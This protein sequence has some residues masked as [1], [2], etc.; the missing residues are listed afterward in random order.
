MSESSNANHHYMDLAHHFPVLLKQLHAGLETLDTFSS[1]LK[2]L[3]AVHAEAE[4]GVKKIIDRNRE[5]QSFDASP[6]V[7][8]AI[9]SVQ[10]VVE[11]TCKIRLQEYRQVN[12]LVV[13]PIVDYI[14]SADK[15]VKKI[16]RIYNEATQ[17]IKKRREDVRKNLGNCLKGWQQLHQ[18]KANFKRK[19]KVHKMFQDHEKL[20]CEV[21]KDYRDFYNMELK[22]WCETLEDLEKNR[23]GIMRDS[24][25]AFKTA[26]FSSLQVSEVLRNDFKGDSQIESVEKSFQHMMMK[27]VKIYGEA[28]PPQEIPTGLPCHSFDLASGSNAWENK[29]VL[30]EREKSPRSARTDNTSPKS[31]IESVDE[32]RDYIKSIAD[33]NNTEEEHIGLAQ[34]DYASDNE[35]DLSFRIGDKIIILEQDKSGWWTGEL[36][37]KIGFFPGNY[38]TI[39]PR[40]QLLVSNKSPTAVEG[41]T[42]KVFRAKL[43][44]QGTASIGGSPAPSRS[45]TRK[46]HHIRNRRT[47][48]R[49]SRSTSKVDNISLIKDF[50]GRGET[51]VTLQNVSNLPL[52]KHSSSRDYGISVKMSLRSS[53]DGHEG[54]SIVHWQQKYK[55]Q[56]PIWNSPRILMP[57]SQS[58][59]IKSQHLYAVLLQE[60]KEEIGSASIPLKS[61]KF[62]VPTTVPV[63]LPKEPGNTKCTLSLTVSKFYPRPKYV[64]FIRHGESEWNL[65]QEKKQVVNMM[66]KV[67]HGLS[68]AGR[69]QAESLADKIRVAIENG[70]TPRSQN[71]FLERFIEADS[72][73][74]S[75]LTRALQTAVIAL[76]H[77]PRLHDGKTVLKVLASARERRNFGGR[78]TQGKRKGNDILV[79]LQHKLERLYKLYGGVPEDVEAIEVDYNDASDEWWDKKKESDED[80]ATRLNHLI[81]HLIFSEEENIIL[82][83]H[84]FLIRG[85]FQQFLGETFRKNNQ[86]VAK[87]FM[88]YKLCNCAVVGVRFSLGPDIVPQIDDVRLLLGSDIESH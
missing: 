5:K 82:V 63:Y 59:D 70:D 51:V 41:K 17:R 36:N 50:V 44:K 34:W 86:Q 56:N 27:W 14:K 49:N 22:Q 21:N 39:M 43:N 64:F 47:N 6:D 37:G 18:E 30:K 29:S 65:A 10:I 4:M 26:F 83:S 3:L 42:P 54:S 35:K 9:E 48:S 60:E 53:L 52:N 32:V 66:K 58:A 46:G 7:N 80:F 62:G 74:S 69:L 23:I 76:M 24:L 8:Q 71:E 78:D 73:Y 12:E 61:V 55:T 13:G 28:G 81:S 2:K 1:F 87:D 77:H 79:R 84:S 25:V 57:T 75:P 40:D 88:T 15:T 20:V 67:D 11:G 72:V 16:S 19:A 31:T 45:P 33:D 68:N 85:I 38:V